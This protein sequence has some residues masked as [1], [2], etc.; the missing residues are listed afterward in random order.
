MTKAEYLER[1][2]FCSNIESLPQADQLLM[3]NVLWQELG[4]NGNTMPEATRA[5][6]I[7]VVAT[8]LRNH[9]ADFRAEI[10]ARQ[11]MN[12]LRNGK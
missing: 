10:T 12:R 7:G 6:L 3:A 2:I 11:L 5:T 1:I 8:L 9:F 4:A